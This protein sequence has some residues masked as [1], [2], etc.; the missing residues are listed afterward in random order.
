V[1]PHNRLDLSNSSATTRDDASTADS[2]RFRESTIAARS[3]VPAHEEAADGGAYQ[4]HGKSGAPLVGVEPLAEVVVSPTALTYVVPEG[5]GLA[6][7]AAD[8]RDNTV[9]SFDEVV[10]TVRDHADGGAYQHPH[11]VGKNGAPL[12]GGEPLVEVVVSPTALPNVVPE[13]RPTGHFVSPRLA[14]QAAGIRDNTVRDHAAPDV[15]APS[16][17][18]ADAALLPAAAVTA[19]LDVPEV[20]PIG[21][22]P[23]E[24]QSWLAWLASGQWISSL[25]AAALELEPAKAAVV[26]EGETCS[27][28]WTPFDVSLGALPTVKCQRCNKHLHLECFDELC[29]AAT[30]NN[31]PYFI[32]VK[33]PCCRAEGKPTPDG[34]GVWRVVPP[35]ERVADE[36]VEAKARAA[37]KAVM[38]TRVQTLKRLALEANFRPVDM[39]AALRDGKAALQVYTSQILEAG[40]KKAIER[41]L[42]AGKVV[43]TVAEVLLDKEAHADKFGVSAQASQ[44]AELASRAAKSDI[45]VKV[46]SALQ[47]MFTSLAK[48]ISSSSNE[49]EYDE[50][51][52]DEDWKPQPQPFAVGAAGEAAV[53][54][55]PPERNVVVEKVG[56][57]QPGPPFSLHALYK[58]G[59]QPQS[60]TVEHLQRIENVKSFVEDLLSNEGFSAIPQAIHALK[61]PDEWVLAARDYAKLE[62][63]AGKV[64]HRLKNWKKFLREKE[65]IL[66]EL[67]SNLEG[68]HNGRILSALRD[69]E[70]NVLRL[71]K[72]LETYGAT[73]D[74]CKTT[75][76]IFQR[77]WGLSEGVVLEKLASKLTAL[78]TAVATAPPNAVQVYPLL[79]E[80]LKQGEVSQMCTESLLYIDALYSDIKSWSD[81]EYHFANGIYQDTV[82]ITTAVVA[83]TAVLGNTRKILG[84]KNQFSQEWRAL[85]S[86]NVIESLVAY[87]INDTNSKMKILLATLPSLSSPMTEKDR[88]ALPF[89]QKKDFFKEHENALKAQTSCLQ[90]LAEVSE[91][92]NTIAMEAGDVIE[93]LY[94]QTRQQVTQMEETVKNLLR[95]TRN[96]CSV[97]E[98][99]VASERLKLEKAAVVTG[100]ACRDLTDAL[101]GKAD[102]VHEAMTSVEKTYDHQ[103]SLILA[104]MEKSIA[105]NDEG[106]T[107][108]EHI[109]AYRTFIADHVK[110][111]TLMETVHAMLNEAAEG[112]ASLSSAVGTYKAAV[113]AEP[114]SGIRHVETC[115]D[116]GFASLQGKFIAAQ[117]YLNESVDLDACFRDATTSIVAAEQALAAYIDAT[118]NTCMSLEETGTVTGNPDE[119]AVNAAKL[120]LEA[121]SRGQRQH[122]T[123]CGT[124]KDL[125][126]QYGESYITLYNLATAEYKVPLSSRADI[127]AHIARI[128]DICSAAR[129]DANAEEVRAAQVALKHAQEAEAAIVRH[130]QAE[131]EERRKKAAAE[132]KERREK[133]AAE[134]VERQKKAAA[135]EV[136]RREKAAVEAH[137]ETV[138]YEEQVAKTL[139]EIATK[140]R[141]TEES[142]AYDVEQKRVTEEQAELE[143]NAATRAQYEIAWQAYNQND[144]RAHLKMLRWFKVVDPEEEAIAAACEYFSDLVPK[145]DTLSA[146]RI[147]SELQSIQDNVAVMDAV[148]STRRTQC[149]STATARLAVAAEM[150]QKTTK[151]KAVAIYQQLKEKTSDIAYAAKTLRDVTAASA[152]AIDLYIQFLQTVTTT[153][154]TAAVQLYI[155]DTQMTKVEEIHEQQLVKRERVFDLYASVLIPYLDA[156]ARNAVELV[157]TLH[158]V[159]QKQLLRRIIERT[160]R[161]EEDMRGMKDTPHGYVKTQAKLLAETAAPWSAGVESGSGSGSASAPLH[162]STNKRDAYGAFDDG[163]V[164]A[165]K[166]RT[167]A[168]TL[169]SSVA[170]VMSA[171]N[172]ETVTHASLVPVVVT[173]ETPETV[174]PASSVPVVVLTETSETVV[175]DL[176]GIMKNMRQ[177][178][179]DKSR[180]TKKEWVVKVNTILDSFS[181]NLPAIVSELNTS[182]ANTLKGATR[183]FM[184]TCT[185]PY[186][187]MSTAFQGASGG[188]YTA[189]VKTLFE[190]AI[191]TIREIVNGKVRS[192]KG[193]SKQ[194][195]PSEGAP[196]DPGANG[197]DSSPQR[198][199]T[200]ESG[201]PEKLRGRNATSSTHQAHR[202]KLSEPSSASHGTDVV[203]RPRGRASTRKTAS[204]EP[205]VPITLKEVRRNLNKAL[206]T[207]KDNAS[208]LSFYLEMYSTN[209][210]RLLQTVTDDDKDEYYAIAGASTEL[211]DSMPTVRNAS[212]KNTLFRAPIEQLQFTLRA[213][214]TLRDKVRKLKDKGGDVTELEEKIAEKEK[215]VAESNPQKRQRR[216]DVPSG[217]RARRKWRFA[218]PVATAFPIRRSGVRRFT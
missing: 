8:I 62:E 82:D 125:Y 182:R 31:R 83:Y 25:D 139:E 212:A 155:L 186:S 157:T 57:L 104:S 81:V 7:Q 124:L 163:N 58:F 211:V 215:D 191:A 185:V 134:E 111:G 213:I 9:A 98:E 108:H 63:D 102:L 172:P 59:I 41:I 151:E 49:D 11:Y 15:I 138:A 22:G 10:S 79:L 126:T 132:E 88:E 1:T 196:S 179:N 118:Y 152:E 54:F 159:P 192:A 17:A 85:N 216:G 84:T 165:R 136:E 3:G 94:A 107:V 113:Q 202:V 147:K 90:G 12:D 48:T 143:R 37:V 35:E 20:R 30:E 60:L 114:P 210:P 103:R 33:C 141:Q 174:T 73:M 166:R 29:K 158:E 43:T 6:T 69:A 214:I 149:L 53:P 13:G 209:M 181:A 187:E 105:E 95:Q 154:N 164:I 190:A 110:L 177:F 207:N 75:M 135:E 194:A 14:A 40:K 146:E 96:V 89:A 112:M 217:G 19:S 27:I 117:K 23:T 204:S 168:R 184:V 137:A 178:P 92:I 160:G 78:D 128:R 140:K 203:E 218:E 153:E 87:N 45:A 169:S 115:Y 142:E 44:L 144:I 42:A 67:S 47:G 51:E 65:Y 200:T 188:E 64:A 129:T 121:T 193:S 180:R 106:K 70:E 97:W 199:S 5:P 72:L 101:L 2:L 189:D 133:A 161:L 148:T 173:T 36:M 123:M 119:G 86:N 52:Y 26:T 120:H 74:R 46:S 50:D 99:L 55:P 21:E 205:V 100:K 71:T 197:S 28:C 167:A 16:V 171:E 198:K 32:P 206:T 4:H 56:G 77:V 68:H 61:S 150:L 24:E 176:I 201:K 116:D 175:R 195:K 131:K 18:P 39:T 76:G 162:P 145:M 170:V 156:Y 34:S 66:K 122:E 93:P 183:R 127:I 130:Q 80:F 208:F 109:G 38:E 91:K